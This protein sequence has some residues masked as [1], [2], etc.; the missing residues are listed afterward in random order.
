PD[1]TPPPSPFGIRVS[2]NRITWQA[3]ADLESGISHFIVRKNG[4]VIGRVPEKP[5]NRFGRPLFQGLQYS[6]TPLQPLAKME[7]VDPNAGDS[8]QYQIISVNTM[9]L[10]SEN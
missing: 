4:K 7:F 9:G 3:Q 1:R 10:M 5:T 2:G 6:D 8:Q